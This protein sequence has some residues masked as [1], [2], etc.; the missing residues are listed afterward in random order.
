MA[1]FRGASS[2]QARIKGPADAPQPPTVSHHDPVAS[3]PAAR[4]AVTAGTEGVPGG[5]PRSR[6]LPAARGLRGHQ[7]GGCWL[8][9][10]PGSDLSTLPAQAQ[11]LGTGPRGPPDWLTGRKALEDPTDPRA[12]LEGFLCTLLRRGRA[13][14]AWGL[15]GWPGPQSSSGLDDSGRGVARDP[16][17]RGR[18]DLWIPREETLPGRPARRTDRPPPQSSAQALAWGLRVWGSG[19]GPRG[20][21]WEARTFP[22]PVEAPGRTRSHAHPFTS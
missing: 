2:P 7:G 1:G 15:G 20:D 6:G 4:C 12:W 19:P 3:L 10:G 22:G 16:P 11:A 13:Q 14:Q 8:R 21:F 9:G 17:T 18:L 5:H